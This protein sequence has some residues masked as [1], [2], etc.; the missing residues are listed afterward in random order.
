MYLVT[1]G[2]NAKCTFVSVHFTDTDTV[3]SLLEEQKL[4]RKK[5]EKN[6]IALYKYTHKYSDGFFFP[7]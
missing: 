4:L 7:A 3:L 6:E 2:N 5:K 1:V